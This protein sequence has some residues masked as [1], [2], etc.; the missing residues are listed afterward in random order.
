[1]HSKARLFSTFALMFATVSCYEV[2]HD[3]PAAET[4]M[5]LDTNVIPQIADPNS[6]VPGDAASKVYEVKSGTPTGKNDIDFNNAVI[7]R[8]IFTLEAQKVDR[9]GDTMTG[10]LVITPATGTSPALTANALAGSAAPGTTSTG[11]GVGPGGFFV[12][13]ALA[14]GLQATPGTPTGLSTPQYALFLNQ[15]GLRF[16]DAIDSP[17]ANADPGY[18]HVMFPQSMPTSSAILQSDGAN[19]FTVVNNVGFN[20][21][22]WSGNASGIATVTFARALPG[23]GYRRHIDIYDGYDARPNGVQNVSNFQFVVRDQTTKAT[24][25]L[26]TTAVTVEVST[27]GY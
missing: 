17:N 18:D 19:N 26:T 20:V 14:P 9:N 23:N 21:A 22:S 16:D 27:I 10:P 5:A 13:G 24:I 12:G 11:D 6:L 3:E 8:Q 4:N 25:D 15:G 7:E 1:M 2:Q